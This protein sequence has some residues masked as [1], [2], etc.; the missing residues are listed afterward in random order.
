MRQQ[1]NQQNLLMFSKSIPIRLYLGANNCVQY[2]NYEADYMLYNS[3]H[4]I[5]LSTVDVAYRLTPAEKLQI[6]LWKA[7]CCKLQNCHRKMFQ[8]SFI[9]CVVVKDAS[10]KQLPNN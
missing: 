4:I 9:N 6:V 7:Y 3:V 8:D 10:S 1:F 2:S 5:N